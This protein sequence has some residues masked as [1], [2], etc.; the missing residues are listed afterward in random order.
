MSFHNNPWNE[1]SLKDTL[2][3]LNDVG[4]KV[5]LEAMKQAAEVGQMGGVT[6]IQRARELF[7]KLGIKYLMELNRL[8][9]PNR[10]FQVVPVSSNESEEHLLVFRPHPNNLTD[11][12]ILSRVDPPTAKKKREGSS[13]KQQSKWDEKFLHLQRFQQQFGHCR[14][15]KDYHDQSFMYWVRTQKFLCKKFVKGEPSQMTADRFRLLES[16][17]FEMDKFAQCWDRRYQELKEFQKSRGTLQIPRDD[18]SL[19]E[20]AR[21]VNV[22]KVECRKFVQNKK[23]TISQHRFNQLKEINFE[24][25]IAKPVVPWEFRFE[26]LKEYMKENGDHMVPHRYPPN[27]ELGLWVARQRQEYKLHRAGKKAGITE[28]RIQKLLGLGFMFYARHAAA[29]K[30][31]RAPAVADDG[32]NEKRQKVAAAAKDDGEDERVACEEKQVETP[33]VAGG[34]NDSP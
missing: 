14:I 23:S 15:P 32:N 21:W 2:K 20:L 22:Q 12:V 13:A 26:Q 27:P 7:Q 33:K 9:L 11:T 17:N 18:P 5:S 16:I 6:S 1:P 4:S 31:K 10:P 25:V 19:I 3:F 30:K 29:K 34:E 8:F 28:E 24:F